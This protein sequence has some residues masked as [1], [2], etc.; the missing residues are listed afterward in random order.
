MKDQN[1]IKKV[2]EN[3]KNVEVSDEKFKELLVRKNK[4]NAIKL[5]QLVKKLKEANVPKPE[6]L[7]ELSKLDRISTFYN[8]IL[9]NPQTLQK[10]N[11]LR[12]FARKI[13]ALKA[14]FK[15]K[16][17]NVY[18]IVSAAAKVVTVPLSFAAS[19]VT[20]GIA[21]EARVNQPNAE[22][23]Y[24]MDRVKQKYSLNKKEDKQADD[25]T[26]LKDLLSRESANHHKAAKNGA[27][28][29]NLNRVKSKINNDKTPETKTSAPKI[30]KNE[31]SLRMTKEGREM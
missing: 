24:E 14:D 3:A 23:A 2:S 15:Q 27:V 13:S 22:N 7:I 20:A 1:T 16:H 29:T 18:K 10:K 12:N 8:D 25:H 5:E 17:P 26:S 9:S 21:P 31:Q 28:K 11:K 4:M 19:L 30:K 6:D